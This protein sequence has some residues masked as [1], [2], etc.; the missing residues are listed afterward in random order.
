MERGSVYGWSELTVPTRGWL[1]YTRGLILS[2][3]FRSRIE[4]VEGNMLNLLADNI[5]LSDTYSLLEGEAT[6][7]L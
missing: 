4:I 7:F 1:L 3:L 5:S 6:L 2:A